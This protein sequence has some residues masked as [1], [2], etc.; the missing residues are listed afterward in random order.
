MRLENKDRTDE[1]VQK[2]RMDLRHLQRYNKRGSNSQ[3][4]PIVIN[5]EDWIK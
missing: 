1:L 4:T 5:M 2:S 3:E